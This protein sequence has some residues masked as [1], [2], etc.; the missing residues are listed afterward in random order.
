MGGSLYY[1]D[2]TERGRT[3]RVGVQRDTVGVIKDTVSARAR[4]GVVSSDETNSDRYRG[5]VTD[6][7]CPCENRLRARDPN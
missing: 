2:E 5:L 1:G 6:Q 7:S 3:D 4:H